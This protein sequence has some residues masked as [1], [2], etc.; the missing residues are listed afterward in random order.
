[1]VAKFQIRSILSAV[2]AMSST[3]VVSPQAFADTPAV[4]AITGVDIVNPIGFPSTE[5]ATIIIEGD[6]ITVIGV[7]SDVAVPKG[8]KI[9]DGTGRWLIPGLMDLHVHIGIGSG[10]LIGTYE[11]GQPKR[12]KNLPSSR[13]NVE[14]TYRNYLRSGITTIRSTGEPGGLLGLGWPYQGKDNLK[15]RA[16]RA[17]M[18]PRLILSTPLFYPRS[19]FPFFNRITSPK[20][21]VKAVRRYAEKSDVD[22]LKIWYVHGKFT[23]ESD[24]D[25]TWKEHLPIVEAMLDEANRIGLPN[26]VDA[27]EVWKAKEVIKRGGNLAHGIFIG[28]VDDEYISL[29]RKRKV[30]QVWTI[31]AT[32]RY[33]DA[34]AGR[35]APTTP[36]LLLSNP[37]VMSQIIDIRGRDTEKLVIPE[38]GSPYSNMTLAEA[39]KAPR[40]TEETENTIENLRR[41][42][43]AGIE[44]GVGTDTG[45]IG[46]PAAAPLFA[47]FALYRR[48]GVSTHEVLTAATINNAKIIDLEDEIGSITE[49][50]KADLVLLHADPLADVM[51]MSEITG[52]MRNGRY[53]TADELNPDTPKDIVARLR[54]AF[55]IGDAD[56]GAALL[57]VN[58]SFESML[59]GVTLLGRDKVNKK[60]MTG[61]DGVTYRGLIDAMVDGPVV[62]QKERWSDGRIVTV[63]YETAGK[64][65]A[66][67]TILSVDN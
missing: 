38:N 16:E 32:E 30:K 7:D 43:E 9:I 25:D 53:F 19:S 26:T 51:N 49:G 15:D 60:Y 1:M 46:M 20:Q 40:F 56:A 21:G 61:A 28:E 13:D 23:G 41:V 66:A 39:M 62:T 47:E 27:I 59:D 6:T 52:V 33:F 14:M 42:H 64:K 35:F 8:A 57:R 3:A 50:K 48:A 29:M 44:F 18:A 12:P 54:N 58:A 11:G 34:V 4:T 65:I 36:E 10:A 67:I 45:I 63:R 22:L 55:N 5:D 2:L 17:I 31:I 24:T 37:N